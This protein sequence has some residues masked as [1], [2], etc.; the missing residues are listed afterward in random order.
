MIFLQDISFSFQNG[1]IC[2][3]IYIYNIY[4]YIYKDHIFKDL[5]DSNGIRISVWK[6]LTG[7]FS[8]LFTF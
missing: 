8:P 3:Y 1:I 4:I 5:M 2:I 7:G 6:A